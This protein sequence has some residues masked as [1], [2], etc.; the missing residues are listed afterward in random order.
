MAAQYCLLAGAVACTMVIPQLNAVSLGG[1]PA[2]AAAW[3]PVSN[4]KSP[5]QL[6]CNPP[7]PP[8]P[9]PGATN[10]ATTIFVATSTVRATAI[11]ALFVQLQVLVLLT[12]ALLR[13][14]VRRFSSVSCPLYINPVSPI[15]VS[16]YISLSAAVVLLL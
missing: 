7:P 2:V 14:A 16:Q 11:S 1:E 12:W 13:A 4:R 10:R 15:L 5:C 3:G 6:Y 8:P 9:A